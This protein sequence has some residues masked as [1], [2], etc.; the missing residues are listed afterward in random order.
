MPPMRPRILAFDIVLEPV[1]QLAP[2]R[3]A[4]R[5]HVGHVLPSALREPQQAAAI[6]WRDRPGQ[7]G[8]DPFRIVAM[9]VP[10]HLSVG[11]EPFDRH[12]EHHA[13]FVEAELGFAAGLVVGNRVR[14]P[15]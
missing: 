1:H 7:G 10:D 12:P 3:I 8:A 6:G 15:P 5:D 9:T 14:G 13:V 11:I 4:G 2:G